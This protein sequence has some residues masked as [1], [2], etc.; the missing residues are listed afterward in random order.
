MF[1]LGVGEWLTT[2][3]GVVSLAS[4]AGVGFMRGRVLDLR[5]QLTESRAETDSLRAS[6]AEDRA[7]LE[8]TKG[9]LKSCRSDLDALTR[10]VTGE[11]HWVALGQHLDEHHQEARAH[12]V[13]SEANTQRMIAALEALKGGQR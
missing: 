5:A 12:W 10:V 4:F 13:R 7:E 6:R 8:R 2:A 1:G 3:I 9:D 11:A